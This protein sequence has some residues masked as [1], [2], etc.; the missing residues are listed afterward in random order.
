[1]SCMRLL[2][3]AFAWVLVAFPA[4][5]EGREPN[6]VIAVVLGQE[7]T[8]ED[9]GG[10]PITSLI[11]EPLMKEFAAGN[12]LQPTEDEIAE[13]VAGIVERA[14]GMQ[15]QALSR[16]QGQRARLEQELKGSLGAEEREMIRISLDALALNIDSLSERQAQVNLDDI[17]RPM[18]IRWIQRWKILKA[19]YD[20]YGGRVIARQTGFAPFD[21]VR[22]FLEE[23]QENGAFRILDQD[24]EDEFW[25]YWRTEQIHRFVPEGQERESIDT[26]PWL[27][28][29][30]FDD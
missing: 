16:L 4:H 20:E 6:D 10:A 2:L 23:Q 18:T 22:E 15:R 8:V 7:I 21:A 9:A 30:P 14:L 27:M 13:S 28:E 29:G 19:L 17:D 26:P 24:Y 5:G 1:M 11:T 25:H 3:V 12:G